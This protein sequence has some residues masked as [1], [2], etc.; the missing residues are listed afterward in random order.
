MKAA[1]HRAASPPP[2]FVLRSNLHF[3]SYRSNL[4]HENILSGLYYYNGNAWL[5][6]YVL[7]VSTGE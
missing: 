4:L 7:I 6:Y 3:S 5:A 1:A 2:L